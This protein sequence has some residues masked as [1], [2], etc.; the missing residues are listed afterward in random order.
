MVTATKLEWHV[1]ED[2]EFSGEWRVEA[3][4]DDGEC[5]ITVFAGTY[6][7]DRARTYCEW[8]TSAPGQ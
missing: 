5:Y 2:K 7:E 8:L 3:V 4:G 6:A 1:F